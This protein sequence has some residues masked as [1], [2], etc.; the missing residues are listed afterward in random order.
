MEGKINITS[1]KYVANEIKGSGHTAIK[2]VIESINK[3]GELA[4]VEMFVPLDPNNRHY[5]AILA[6]VEDGNTIEAAD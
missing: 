3:E 5:K 6:W 4:D 2:A 1:A